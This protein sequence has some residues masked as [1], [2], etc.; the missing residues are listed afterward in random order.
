MISRKYNKRVEIWQTIEKL[1][2]YGGR[3]IDELFLTKSWANIVSTGSNRTLSN[4]LTDLGISDIQNT[5]IINLRHRNDF[6]YNGIN[7]FIQYRGQK[8]IIQSVIEKGLE[9]TEV[10]IIATREKTKNVMEINLNKGFPLSFSIQFI[11]EGNLEGF[12]INLR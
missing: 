11:N 7:Q 4:R 8:Y 6:S 3:L 9:N 1:D 2:G 12:P 10:E 5:I